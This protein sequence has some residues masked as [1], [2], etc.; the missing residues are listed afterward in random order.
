MSEDVLA[1]ST[2]R[3]YPGIVNVVLHNLV[4]V[5]PSQV[6]LVE[7]LGKVPVVQRLE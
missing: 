4:L 2:R 7:G 5:Q 1:F 6:T 3:T